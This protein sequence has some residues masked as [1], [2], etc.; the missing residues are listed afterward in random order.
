MWYIYI[1]ICSTS[2]TA[3]CVCVLR[4]TVSRNV[5][6]KWLQSAARQYL[7]FSPRKARKLST[8]SP[9]WCQPCQP[10]GHSQASAPSA[11]ALHRASPG[12]QRLRCQYLY[13]CTSK[14]SKLSTWLLLSSC[15][16]AVAFASSFTCTFERLGPQQLSIRQH[17][18]A[19]RQ[20]TS[21]YVSPAH[22]RD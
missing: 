6:L 21:A 17:T 19:Y 12:T 4:S 2:L 8:W 16:C 18:S 20:H 22:S 1:L 14:A 15:T 11:S 7:S 5:S 9:V 13:F 3:A 10:R